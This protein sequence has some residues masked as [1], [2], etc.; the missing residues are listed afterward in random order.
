MMRALNPYASVSD[1]IQTL[2]RTAQ[3]PRDATW[4]SALGW[5]V[6]DAG[7][8]VDAIRRLDR[9]APTSRLT[10]R[11]S[12]VGREI[13]LRWSGHDR[14]R[15]GLVT[16]GIAYYDV[17]VA[18]DG[19]KPRRIARSRRHA[20]T[21]DVRPGH[22]YAFYSVAVDR[23]GNRESKPVRTVVRAAG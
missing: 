13:V 23:A 17:Y 12:T 3:R 16:S 8:A 20:L 22:T 18:T 5:G 9:L 15:R 21:F 1:V 11:R 4:G 14:R 10:A 7:A 19:G 6:L 2:K